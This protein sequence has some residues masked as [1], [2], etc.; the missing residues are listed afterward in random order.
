VADAQRAYT[1]LQSEHEQSQR[2]AEVLATQNAE[3]HEKVSDT[4]KEVAEFKNTLKKLSGCVE[5]RALLLV[6]QVWP[7]LS[8]VKTLPLMNDCLIMTSYPLMKLV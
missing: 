8:C 3:L 4:A 7:A 1:A 5:V 6:T 2:H